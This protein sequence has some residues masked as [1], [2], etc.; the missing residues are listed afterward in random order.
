MATDNS[1]KSHN[2]GRLKSV[3]VETGLDAFVVL[4]PEN[5]VYSTGAHF[6][7]SDLNHLMDP[8][9]DYFTCVI[10]ANGEPTLLVWKREYTL[11]QQM[12]WVNDIRDYPIHG[13]LNLLVDVLKEKNLDRARIGVEKLYMPF[14]IFEHLHQALPQVEFVAGD[15]ALSKARMVKSP[16]EIE[17]LG[18]V[19]YLTSKAIYLAWER[20]RLGDR[21]RDICA[22]MTNHV[23][24]FGAEPQVF[25]YGSGPNSLPGHRWGDDRRLE[26]GDIVHSDAKGRLRGYWADVSRNCVVGTPTPQ[27][28]D[29][30]RRLVT[31]HDRV[32]EQLRP[33]VLSSEIYEL[34]MRA[35]QEE[36]IE[37][38]PRL[39]CHGIGTSLHEAPL[40]EPNCEPIVL[41]EGMVV[42]VEPAFY[43]PEIFYHYE[44]M[45]VITTKGGDV[46][47][48][49]ET[50][51][52]QLYVI[53]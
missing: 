16:W 12:S 35:N 4:T 19:G 1:G 20:A 27:Q 48:N 18:H 23:M 49:Y 2:I 21:E 5:V 7:W 26:L 24:W 8:R 52:N 17:T 3:M 47:S 51:P 36:G 50:D 9:D 32:V 53:R 42:T 22:D 10:P 15:G 46:L 30:Y 33:G 31:I 29:I 41:E 45:V 34:Y 6:V 44:N 38:P 14:G 43:D 11:A 25:S 37:V 28:A 13:M 39:I 40:I